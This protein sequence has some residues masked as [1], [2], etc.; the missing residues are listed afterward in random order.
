[1]GDVVLNSKSNFSAIKH[2][3]NFAQNPQVTTERTLPQKQYY[4]SPFEK[5]QDAFLIKE[6]N[7]KKKHKALITTAI[8]TGSIA[9]IAILFSIL[10]KGKISK[11]IAKKLGEYGQKLS[12]KIE[13]LKQQQA[14]NAENSKLNP[15]NITK[16]QLYITMLQKTHK[17]LMMAR[18]A[19]F[20]FTPFKDVLFEKI[21]CDKLKLRKPCDA[22]TRGFR[23]LSH[24]TVKSNYANAS[25]SVNNMTTLFTETNKALETGQIVGAKPVTKETMAKL[26]E[27]IAKVGEEFNTHFSETAIKE[28]DKSVSSICKNLSSRVY[29]KIYGN[30]KNFVKDVKTMTT[31]IPEMLI[32]KDKSVFLKS[33]LAKKRI[34]T[35]NPLDNYKQISESISRLE[36][37][38]NPNDI[39]SRELIGALRKLSREYINA[40][41]PTEEMT[42]INVG[43]QINAL[44]KQSKHTTN[45]AIY[46]PKEA[47][48]IKY[49]LGEIGKVVNTDK[50]GLIEELLSTYKEILPPEKY[51]ELKSSAQK[52]TDKINH[53][54]IQEGHEYVD[55]VRDLASGSALTDVA[56]GLALPLGSTAIA[57]SASKTKEKKQSVALKYGIPILTGVMTSTIATV[58]LVSGGKALGLGLA[59]T[60][61]TNQVCKKI[62]DK[63]K[64]K[65]AKSLNA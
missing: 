13:I 55:K 65:K 7:E 60:F 56:F 32:E 25:K 26:N 4:S 9:S 1:M 23:K 50:K 8:A 22:I 18:G 10:T 49:Q 62:D 45:S 11:S 31:F 61:V 30:L 17:G 36:R 34:I 41:G 27:K 19:I 47:T 53:A 42:R 59:S 64:E 35:N 52:A 57:V 21:V 5:P 63:L 15:H 12:E 38:I 14:K 43:R 28:R 39:G 16:S 46:S 6:N 37:S 51:K 58:K 33:I 24:A 3:I 48:Y 29:E 40:S 20:N 44:I 2:G 54:T